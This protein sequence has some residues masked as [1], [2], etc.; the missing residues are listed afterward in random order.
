MSPRK[1][2]SCVDMVPRRARASQAF[3]GPGETDPGDTPCLLLTALLGGICKH[4]V[5][6]II[7]G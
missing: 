3:K 7:D 5:K 1:E 2:G 4:F 6:A